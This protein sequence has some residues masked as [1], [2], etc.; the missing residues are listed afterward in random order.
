MI[1]SETKIAEIKKTY[2]HW[3]VICI[4]ALA[5]IFVR[6]L[7]V[8]NE[9][10]SFLEAL[11]WYP[12]LS[13]T[14]F[15][16]IRLTVK[17]TVSAHRAF[18]LYL[19]AIGISVFASLLPVWPKQTASMPLGLSE[20]PV[21]FLSL[22]IF[23]FSAGPDGFLRVLALVSGI[24]LGVFVYKETK[25]LFA[26]LKRALIAWLVASSVFILP[27]ILLIFAIAANG[28]AINMPAPEMM[29][30]FTRINLFS[31]WS[32]GQ[33]LRWFTGFGSQAANALILYS[34]SAIFTLTAVLFAFGNRAGIINYFKT[35]K[36]NAF[37]M[38]LTLAVYGYASGKS[39]QGFAGLDIAAWAALTALL[40]LGI[41]INANIDREEDGALDVIFILGGLVLGWP[42]FLGAVILRLFIW[43]KRE[44]AQ[45][46]ALEQLFE[47]LLRIGFAVLILLFMRRGMIIEAEMLKITGLFGVMVLLA[48]FHVYA[49]NMQFSKLKILPAWIGSS[50][51]VWVM[52]GIFTPAAILL[53]GAVFAWLFWDKVKTYK[54]E[55][56]SYIWILA[57][58][59]YLVVI[60]LPRLAHP[61]L[62]PR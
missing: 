58:A 22:G 26:A 42:V 48:S 29:N 1:K 46:L 60:Y 24:L 12:L 7:L 6:S 14:A 36:P 18:I 40:F 23:P 61:E 28:F 3:L 50:L 20:V 44:T 62:I 34:A 57:L 59:I 2:S 43:A 16:G 38:A 21:Y 53:L 35:L 45:S 39:F 25:D 31:Y 9:Y 52:A 8:N 27:S 54:W 5:A 55:F 51:L 19:Y 10:P 32:D 4:A 11:I 56:N 13:V 47:G 33:I 49:K 41:L 17:K 37:L 15:L 30:E